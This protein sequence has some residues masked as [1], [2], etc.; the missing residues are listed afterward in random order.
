M[1]KNIN[2]YYIKRKSVEEVVSFLSQYD[3][4]SFDIFDT[5]IL[6]KV[7]EPSDLFR[8]LSS[9]YNVV[10]F[11]KTRRKAEKIA[12]IKKQKDYGHNEITIDEIY[13]EIK[14]RTNI[15]KE[16][17]IKNEFTLEMDFC[18]ANPYMKKIYDQILKLNK[19]IIILS[20]MYWPKNKIEKILKKCGYEGY[21]KLFISCEYNASKSNGELFKIVQNEIDV[22]KIIHIGDNPKSDIE[23]A[24]KIGWETYYYEKTSNI[25]TE[26]DL[27]DMSTTIGS[28][29]KA[30]VKN[31]LN[32]KD[33]NNLLDNIH[34]YYGYVF[35][36]IMVLG[37]VNWIYKYAKVNNID[38]I[39][40]LSRDGY[41]LKQVYD[42]IYQ[43][44]PSEYV[45]WSRHATLKTAPEK[46]LERFIFQFFTRNI[47]DNKKLI[48]EEVLDS[49]NL[50]FLEPELNKR[51]ISKTDVVNA[52]VKN[53][54]I[55]LIYKNIDQIIENNKDI[56]MA[57]KLF[58]KNI[59]KNSKNICFV[60]IGFRASGAIALKNLFENDWEFE[61]NVK[62]LIA[63]GLSKTNSFDDVLNLDDIVQSYVFSEMKN[64]D[65]SL[66]LQSN[67]T[68]NNSILEILVASAPNPSFLYFQFDNKGEILKVYD[69]QE[70]Y[71][72]ILN[73]H[74]GIL[75]FIDDYLGLSR[76]YTFLMNIAGRDAATPLFYLFEQERIKKFIID[77]SSVPWDPKVSGLKF[78]NQKTLKETVNNL[79]YL[80]N[81][82]K[83]LYFR[84]KIRNLVKKIKKC[85]FIILL[86]KLRKKVK[87]ICK[88]K[89]LRAR[90]FY[91]Y[92]YEKLKIKKNIVLLESYVGDNF[93]GNS[94]YLFK[95]LYN[96][97]E[98]YKF[99]IGV[100]NETRNEI[101]GFLKSNK[102]KKIT[103]LKINSRKYCKILA[104]AKFLIN[105]VTFPSYFIKRKSQIYINTWHGTPLKGLGRSI[106][107]APHE[108][109]NCSRNFCMVD[110]FIMPNKYTFNIMKKD[111]MID[112]I[113]K[114]EYIFAGYPRNS[115]FYNQKNRNYIRK[116][117]NL[118]NKKIIVY[119]PTWRRQDANNQQKK[120]N[121]GIIKLLEKLNSIVNKETDVYVKFHN[122]TK[123][124]ANNFPNLKKFPK[125]YETYEFLNIAD[126]LITDYSSVMFDYVNL[127]KEVILYTYDLEEYV[128]ERTIYF[129]ITNLPFY[130]TQSANEVIQYIQNQ[131]LD[132][133]DEYKEIKSRFCNYDNLYATKNI[134]DYIIGGKT[135][136]LKI[137]KA[138]NNIKKN[139]LIYLGGFKDI[140]ENQN[141]IQFF[142]KNNFNNYNI[143]FTFRYK[144]LISNRYNINNIP[145]NINY[146]IINEGKN[147]NL[148]EGLCLYL[149]KKFGICNNLS[150]N[151]KKRI[152]KRE[153]IKLFPNMKFEFVIDFVGNSSDVLQTLMQMDTK[154]YLILNKTFLV[155]GMHSKYK[156]TVRKYYNKFDVISILENINLEKKFIEV[157][158]QN[159]NNLFEGK[160]KQFE[161][162]DFK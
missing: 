20:D 106:K 154:K 25:K 36:G 85:F 88:N 103:L 100:K 18:F 92:Y 129:P 26:I 86:Q 17:G 31:N 60:D 102:Y 47:V 10:D 96:R 24:K 71:N 133:H 63:F 124:N 136:D 160:T 54:L 67:Q 16:I 59:I 22:S 146:I 42:K 98:N 128:Q 21:D 52:R 75:D 120:P 142:K 30:I 1:E 15:D 122:I 43:D 53:V 97:N 12:R 66:I 82:K 123:F 23:N 14:I 35:S 109:G 150:E 51:N 57:A 70:D 58:Y 77:F 162:I 134:I 148:I 49:M 161:N 125:E 141:V 135:D 147:I 138:T 48:L 115:E 139:I 69:E 93:F 91:T 9:K 99:Y 121:Q 126:C 56:K 19:K 40:F 2:K 131:E 73:V 94:Y 5:L 155:P 114:G 8:I 105:N 33:E 111:Y 156:K 107:E 130:I 157:N 158:I 159:K 28:Y 41:I 13:D 32:N 44:I 113:F 118:N 112:N 7:L 90:I 89:L 3:I 74:N 84:K 4:I 46:D 55:D 65:L 68:L 151:Y 39:L 145:S 79:E 95:E 78:K 127:N 11:Y 37:Y 80:K 62:A 144:S 117:L 101:K 104:S 119:M 143:Y 50:L 45:L 38:K 6:R 116:K 137:E 81:Q 72:I 110:Y 87:K 34:Y 83:L 64:I 152:F 149:Q 29:Y 76:K 153:A 27:L 140:K 61:C 108:S 132:K